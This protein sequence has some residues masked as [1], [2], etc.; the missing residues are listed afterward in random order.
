[1][2]KTDVCH[3]EDSE[4]SYNIPSPTFSEDNSEI[5]GCSACSQE[6]YDLVSLS[7]SLANIFVVHA[8][9]PILRIRIQISKLP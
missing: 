7:L 5:W 2:Y 4:D 6:F 8:K 9:Y 1:M 3:P